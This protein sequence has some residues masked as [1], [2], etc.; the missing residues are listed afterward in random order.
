MRRAGLASVG[1]DGDRPAGAQIGGLLSVQQVVVGLQ[2]RLDHGCGVIAPG[3]VVG[4]VVD[5]LARHDAPVGID[6]ETGHGYHV[7]HSS[8]GDLNPPMSGNPPRS[9]G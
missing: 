6:D 3:E 7:I 9:P 4:M 1:D 8:S 2:A 5:A